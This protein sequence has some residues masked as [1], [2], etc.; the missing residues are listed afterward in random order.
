MPN[1]IYIYI[2]M[3]PY[4]YICMHMYMHVHIDS[5]YDL[6]VVRWGTNCLI[7]GESFFFDD[8]KFDGPW[9]EDDD[10]SW[11]LQIP[12][13]CRIALV[14]GATICEAAY[15]AFVEDPLNKTYDIHL[16]AY[17]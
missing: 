13:D 5:G 12:N 15:M 8:D 16:Y 10:P 17:I 11:D 9:I 6:H 7:R 2:C 3:F 1:Y 4:V 14:A